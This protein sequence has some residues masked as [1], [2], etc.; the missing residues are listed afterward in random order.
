MQPFK[1]IQGLNTQINPV[2]LMSH[3]NGAKEMEESGDKKFTFSNVMATQL[4]GANDV[5]NQSGDF[6]NK[7]LKGEIKNPHD[8]A[9]SGKKAGIMV[10]LTSAVCSKVTSACTTLFQMQI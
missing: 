4:K 6:T 1:P 10:K 3:T 8:V 2:Q 5:V 9:I 7:L